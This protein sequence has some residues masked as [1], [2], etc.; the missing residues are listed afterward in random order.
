MVKISF[1]NIR[2]VLTQPE[3]IHFWIE[4]DTE[5]KFK[6]GNKDTYYNNS[7][8]EGISF[9]I[10]NNKVL[11]NVSINGELKNVT[12]YRSS[13]WADDIP[14]VWIHRD[15]TSAGPFSYII[16]LEGE[17][18]INFINIG[19]PMRT[20][21][22]DNIFPVT[23]YNFRDLEIKLI[24]YTPISA[25]GKERPRGVIYGMY[26]KNKGNT[27]VKG[28]VVIPKFS[29]LFKTIND[30][31]RTDEIFVTVL[32]GYG[33]VKEV[34][35]ELLPGE[36]VWVP[37]LIST[38]GEG[39]AERLNKE[40]SLY[41][42]CSTWSFYRS[43]VGK[44]SMSD[45]IFLQEFFEKAIYQCFESINMDGEDMICGSNWGSN[46][47]TRQVW[48]K[49]MYYSFLPLCMLEP[50]IFK[51]GMLWFAKY[52]VR[53]EGKN[54]SGGVSHSLSNSLTP[55]IMSG[56]YY[57]YT[58]DREFFL[59]NPEL[60]DRL[61]W[62]LEEV[63]RSRRDDNIWMFPS[64]WISD[65]ISYGHFHT[66]SNIC[67]WFAFKSFARVLEEVF[68]DKERASKYREISEK[69]KTDILKYNTIDGPFGK[70]FVE[71]SGDFLPEILQYFEGKSD[72]E[73]EEFMGKWLCQYYKYY[74]LENKKE[75][76]FH[77]GE[78]SDTTL[79]PF[80]GFAPYDNKIYKNYTRFALSE[81]NIMYRPISKG[82]VWDAMTDSTFPGYITGFANVIDKETMNGENGYFAQ[83]KKL[84]DIDGSIWWWPYP[85]DAKHPSEG[86]QRYPGKCGW[87]SGVFVSLFI[88]EILGLKY[89]APTKSLI[90]R[91]FSPS[92]DFE[93]KDFH[94]GEGY[95]SV[96][97]RRG[98]AKTEISIT[99]Q[100][101]YDV[102]CKCIIPYIKSDKEPILTVNG[103][104]FDVNIGESFLGSSTVICNV[105]IPA[106]EKVDIELIFK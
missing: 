32:D 77:D 63:I 39:I 45:D 50:N 38:P 74:K 88:S 54:C 19:L 47:P 22:L 79:M 80:Y 60:K 53:P 49:D 10:S 3:S 78:E 92:S 83:I 75:V 93:W 6:T 72:K 42:L 15:F 2:E 48:M 87:A 25:D 21:F 61:I 23:T 30:K 35:F 103:K 4:R 46:P 94:L 18:E 64:I 26:I 68:S 82:I 29:N 86:C 24:T 102:N 99:N 65:G 104:F 70:Q 62:I 14:G 105:H 89:D 20:S 59:N 34:P 16:S 9:D 17:G 44:L 37:T 97:L 106:E 76:L 95:F 36:D 84:T 43:L 71:G 8:G 57:Q 13:Y 101:S 73:V 51:K 56:L 27:K 31:I 52:S 90:F 81:Y 5:G 12:I 40:G 69:I 98:G 67:A 33:K 58:G 91:P 28:S 7:I 55:V 85:Y 66:G 11:A 96:S 100:N 41:W 1:K